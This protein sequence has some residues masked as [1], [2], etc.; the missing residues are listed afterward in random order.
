MELT[1]SHN[2]V[3]NTDLLT[4]GGLPL[5]TISTPRKWSGR[6]TTI[7]KYML[8]DDGRPTDENMELARIR[9]HHFGSSQLIYD[10]QILD[11]NVF[12]PYN[13]LARRY[14]RVVEPV[15][16]NITWRC[17]VRT[18]VGSDGKSYRWRLGWFTSTVS[19]L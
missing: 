5:Y 6:T 3:I 10:G 19:M 4:A 11:F 13:G 2:S 8:G 15:C 12:M 7:M 16:R 1:L 9:W 17:R 14:V 18:F